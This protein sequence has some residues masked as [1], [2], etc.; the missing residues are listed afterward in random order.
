MAGIAQLPSLFP[1]TVADR[2]ISSAVIK[3]MFPTSAFALNALHMYTNMSSSAEIYYLDLY[4]QGEPAFQISKLKL[5]FFKNHCLYAEKHTQLDQLLYLA[6][7]V[8][9]KDGQQLKKRCMTANSL[10]LIQ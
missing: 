4:T 7:N 8:V 1:T 9:G 6:T 3:Q 5:I 10:V 2:E